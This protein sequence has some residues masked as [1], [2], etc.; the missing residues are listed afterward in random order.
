MLFNILLA[1]LFSILKDVDIAS[2]ADDNIR[3]YVIVDYINGVMA[4]LEKA[5]KALFEWFENNL[6]KSNVD[7][8]HFKFQ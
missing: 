2:H 1:D 5:S 3:S 4:S 6:L 7:K 8:C